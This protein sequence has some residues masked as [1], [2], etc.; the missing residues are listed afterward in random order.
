MSVSLTKSTWRIGVN[1]VVRIA[2]QQGITWGQLRRAAINNYCDNEGWPE[3]E[4][5]G[6]SDGNIIVVNMAQYDTERLVEIAVGE[7]EQQRFIT[8]LESQGIDLNA[9]RRLLAPA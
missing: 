6:S 3:G 5:L 9:M 8:H 2:D 1:R 7:G 4:G